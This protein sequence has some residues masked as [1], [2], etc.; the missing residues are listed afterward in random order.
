MYVRL[1]L[2]RLLENCLFVKAEKSEFHTST[3]SFLGFVVAWTALL[4]SGHGEGSEGVVD[5]LFP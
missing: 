4:R 3:I 1:V 5:S 2:Q